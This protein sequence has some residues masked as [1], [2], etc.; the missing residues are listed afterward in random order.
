MGVDR[1]CE[2]FNIVN[3]S[4]SCHPEGRQGW[5]MDA[6]KWKMVWF[7]QRDRIA[8]GHGPGLGEFPKIC[9][10]LQYLHSG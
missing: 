10:P 5:E 8:C 1:I 3:I 6:E 7:L 4:E 9:V 2:M